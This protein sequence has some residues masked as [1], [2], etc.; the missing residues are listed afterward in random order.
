MSSD[1]LGLI[2]RP[3]I[4]ELEPSNSSKTFKDLSFDFLRVFKLLDSARTG[5]ISFLFSPL[6]L[7]LRRGQ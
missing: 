6:P 5:V 3:S 2:I 4:L 1:P 7:L